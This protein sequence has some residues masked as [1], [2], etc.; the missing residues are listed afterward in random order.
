LLLW[1]LVDTFRAGFG[2]QAGGEIQDD[3]EK[4]GQ[5]QRQERRQSK[6]G[7]FA[8]LRMTS[9]VVY[10]SELRMMSKEVLRY[11]QDDK[12]GGLRK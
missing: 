9:V 2:W 3:I 6:S 5:R 8:A 1:V 7:S 11:A 12:F 4:Q 10:E